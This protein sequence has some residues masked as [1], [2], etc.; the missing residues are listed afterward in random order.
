MNDATIQTI[1]SFFTYSFIYTHFRL[2]PFVSDGY[3]KK[4]EWVLTHIPKSITEC[5]GMR[6]LLDAP[7]MTWCDSYM[8]C[9]GYIDRIQNIDHP[10]MLGT[11]IF[12][13]AFIAIRTFDQEKKSGV[14]IL[15]QRYSDDAGTWTY[16][17]RHGQAWMNPFRYFCQRNIIHNP[18][19]IDVLKSHV[20]YPDLIF[21]TST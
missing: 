16:G 14:L 21:Q 9:T 11:D 1:L 13:R 4:E 3:K 17:T 20:Q 19:W 8:G 18:E 2:T 10:I 12:G 6:V 15:F 7:F 5:I